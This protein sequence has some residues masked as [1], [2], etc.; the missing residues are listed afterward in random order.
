MAERSV[1]IESER[2]CFSVKLVTISWDG[3]EC[4]WAAEVFAQ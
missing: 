4:T 1:M 3:Y 2:R